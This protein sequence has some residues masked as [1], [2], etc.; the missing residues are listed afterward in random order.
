MSLIDTHCHLNFGAFRNDYLKVAKSALEVGINKIIIVGSNAQTSKK[1]IFVAKE[2]NNKAGRNFAFTAV[3]IHPMHVD[4]INKFQEISKIASD[5]S[6]VAIGETGFDFYHD[7]DKKT[8]S[9]QRDLFIKHIDLSAKTGKPLI[10]HN[11]LADLETE[12][13]LG[14]K[15]NL[16]AVF[17]CFSSDHKFAERM[18]KKGFFISLTGNVT[19]GNKKLKRV[20]E[21]VPLER[22]MTETDSP[23]IVPEPLR[24]SGINRNEPKYVIEV[25]KKIA[26]VKDIELDVVSKV[27]TENALNFF[28]FS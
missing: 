8:K 5:P 7:V 12:E 11:R 23:Y 10:I 27:T 13:I 24:S 28:I 9:A 19:Y 25:A 20:I 18:L 4:E 1:A 26:R 6:V 21:E 14:A 3:G 15:S 22:I 2:I 17:H 16:R